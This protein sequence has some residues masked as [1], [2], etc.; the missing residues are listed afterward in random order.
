MPITTAL[1][2]GT[3]VGLRG[4]AWFA[5]SEHGRV[6][7]GTLV[8]DQGGGVT[9]TWAYGGTIP[10]R[11]DP[12]AG[13]ELLAAGKISDRSTHLVQTPPGTDVTLNNRFWVDGRGIYEVTGVQER[14]GEPL[15]TFEVVKIEDA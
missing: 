10:C 13:R 5:L 14:T 4:L 3:F 15:R 11:I 8:D 9:S 12:L 1:N 7:A 2:D 6:G